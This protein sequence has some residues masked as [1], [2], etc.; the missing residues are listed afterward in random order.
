MELAWYLILC[1]VVLAL[2][3][4]VFNYV[5]IKKMPEGTPDMVEMSGIIRSGANAF[6][7]TEF[8]AIAVVVAVIAVVFTL[9]VEV[10][11]GATFLVGA[12]M[13]STV[14]ILGMK[15][16]T[17]ANVRTANKARESMNIGQTVKVALAGGS[18]SGLSVQALGMLGLV[19]IILVSGGIDPHAEGHGLLA[20]LTCNPTIM[21]I[22]T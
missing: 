17:Y 15:S 9:F 8:K 10:S 19:A 14:C 2:A 22:T 21:R 5:R 3:Y 16:A 20:N 6:L 13:S 4:V 18:I 11:S 7:K 12:A 1:L